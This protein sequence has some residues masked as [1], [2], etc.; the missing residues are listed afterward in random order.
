MVL[1]FDDVA[2]RTYGS[3]GLDQSLALMAEMPIPRPW[4]AT[5]S[6]NAALKDQ[7]LKLPVGG[8]LTAPKVDAKALQ[9]AGAQFVRS[10]AEG[11]ILEGLNR[12]L[13]RLLGPQQR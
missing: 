11:V 13:E 2:I 5:G 3:V 9:Q 1:E 4:I 7:T 8:T 6:A 12:G 10:G